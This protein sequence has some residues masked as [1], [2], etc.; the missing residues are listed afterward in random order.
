MGPRREEPT[1]TRNYEAITYRLHDK[2][3]TLVSETWFSLSLES[4]AR[5]IY[6]RFCHRQVC[7]RCHSFHFAQGVSQSSLNNNA[8]RAFRVD[9]ISKIRLRS[10]GDISRVFRTLIKFYSYYHRQYI[11]VRRNSI[12]DETFIFKVWWEKVRN[13][14]REYDTTC[15]FACDVCQNYPSQV[16]IW[17]SIKIEKCVNS[18][19]AFILF[20]LALSAW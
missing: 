1:W 14:I 12:I 9:L 17:Q 7:P 4:V 11:F 10:Q 15:E 5:L 19:I 16:N 20:K 18:F 6:K 3:D 8:R 2:I 13:L